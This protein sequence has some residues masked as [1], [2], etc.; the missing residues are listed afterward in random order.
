MKE[1]QIAE[2]LIYQIKQWR[3]SLSSSESLTNKNLINYE[4]EA[5]VLKETCQRWLEFLEDLSDND[6]EGEEDGNEPS[7]I[8]KILKKIQDLKQAIKLYY[9]AGI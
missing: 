9:E 7:E 4:Q 1:T 6:M 8:K 2:K 3:A 5:K